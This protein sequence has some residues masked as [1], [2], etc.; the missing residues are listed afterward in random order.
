M[1]DFSWQ[2][3]LQT[4]ISVLDKQYKKA[5]KLTNQLDSAIT[6]RD[7]SQLE[8]IS[9]KIYIQFNKIYDYEQPLLQ[10]NKNQVLQ[11]QLQS[12]HQFLNKIDDLTAEIING[13][14]M[15]A[16]T[17]LHFEVTYWLKE[18]LAM[19]QNHLLATQ[20]NHEVKQKKLSAWV[21][22]FK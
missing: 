3:D 12:Y 18:H 16:A 1:N 7:L 4:G 11:E 15:T 17:K 8:S 22:I 10:N 20:A 13:D 19:A 9:Q 5:F 14:K 21:D 6:F 2:A